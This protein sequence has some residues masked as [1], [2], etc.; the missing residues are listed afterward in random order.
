MITM[1][2]ATTIMTIMTGGSDD[3]NNDDTFKAMPLMGS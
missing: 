2:M 1:F 3:K